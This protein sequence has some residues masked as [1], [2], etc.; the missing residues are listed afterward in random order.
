M[1]KFLK[2]FLVLL[3]LLGTI[4]CNQIDTNIIKVDLRGK[5]IFYTIDVGQGDGLLIRTPNENFV[6]IDAGSEKE[7]GKFIDFLDKNDIFKIDYVIATHP[8]E[9]HIGNID[10]V[11]NN[12][13]VKKVYMPKVTANTKTFEKLM[14]AIKSKNLKITTAKAG[15]SF[16]V[17]GVRFDFL[18]PN[19]DRYEDLNNYSAVLKVTYNNNTMLLMGDAEK[20]SEG[21][22]IKKYDVKADIIKIGHHGSVSSTGK[23]FIKKVSPKYAVISCGRDNDYGHPHKETLEILNSLGINILRTDES[24]TIIF[25][26]DGQNIELLK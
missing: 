8:H 14:E 22:I 19:K 6:L 9:D 25:A 18:A 7:E 12:Y 2:L 17:D 13:D 26:M 21:E 4:S 23:S 11:I 24:G 10:Y 20:L 3:I 1:K 5:L 15:Q 16:E